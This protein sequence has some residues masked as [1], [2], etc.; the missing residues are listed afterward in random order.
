MA[1]TKQP[2]RKDS[3][4]R[5]SDYASKPDPPFFDVL[6]GLAYGGIFAVFFGVASINGFGEMWVLPA[7]PIEKAIFGARII[8][9]V[10]LLFLAFR[11]IIATHHELDLW[12]RWLENPF[13]RQEMY[14][15]IFGLSVDLGLL[16]AFPHKI[17]YISGFITLHFLLNYWTQWLSNDHFD[18]ALQKTRRTRLGKARSKVLEEMES[19]WLKRPQLGRVTTM[20]FFSFGAFSLAFAGAFQQEAQRLPYQLIAYIVLILDILIGE[21]VIVRWRR[22]LEQGLRHA[23]ESE[24]G[25][26]HAPDA[27]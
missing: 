16:L 20:M 15:A 27:R 5:S 19:F 4:D 10:E 14:A 17:V 13:G 7:A 9:F 21:I 18:L 23:I 11:W 24:E 25:V 12:L 1:R 26:R 8:L 3:Y 2:R 6:R 22:R